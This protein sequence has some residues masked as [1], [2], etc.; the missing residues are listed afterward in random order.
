M[1]Q[2]DKKIYLIIGAA[3]I[4]LIL[5]I[6]VI[7]LLSNRQKPGTQKPPISSGS[8]TQSPQNS[9]SLQYSQSSPLTSPVTNPTLIPVVPFTGVGEDQN[10]S[11]EETLLATQKQTLRKLMPLDEAGFSLSFDYANDTFQVLLKDPKDSSLSLFN[12][13]LKTNY[14]ALPLDRF[15]I[16]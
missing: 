13:W 14:P 6:S 2:S 11:P 16:K 12:Q 10:I 8:P 15:S 7:L 1:D 4:V 3:I 9:S 5:V